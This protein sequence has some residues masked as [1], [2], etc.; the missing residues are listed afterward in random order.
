[1]VTNLAKVAITDPFWIP[2]HQSKN[3]FDFCHI[4]MIPLLI[5]LSRLAACCKGD[6]Y[7]PILDRLEE[8]WVPTLVIWGAQDRLLP[9]AHAHQA[10]KRLHDARVHI[11][12]PCGHV[13]NIERAHVFNALVIDFLSNG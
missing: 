8:I 6:V 13:P 11:F 4:Y 12:D 7:H 3:F 2:A 1:M 5:L 10:A 9:A